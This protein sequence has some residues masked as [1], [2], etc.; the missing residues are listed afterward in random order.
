VL[1]LSM[2][3]KE[4]IRNYLLVKYDGIFDWS[5]CLK[6]FKKLFKKEKNRF[7][8]DKQMEPNLK[9]TYKTSSIKDYILISGKHLTDFFRLAQCR[10]PKIDK[11]Y[12]FSLFKLHFQ[13]RFR[14]IEYWWRLDQFIFKQFQDNW[15]TLF[16]LLFGCSTIIN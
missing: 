7:D 2:E 1:V 12:L 10:S 5:Y 3:F 11:F 9:C 8:F 14:F 15:I 13:N 4:R 16:L 6:Y